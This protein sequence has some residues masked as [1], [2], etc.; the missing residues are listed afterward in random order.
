[1][2]EPDTPVA[3]LWG[4]WY[5]AFLRIPFAI[6]EELAKLAAKHEVKAVTEAIEITSRKLNGV[7]DDMRRISYIH[8]ILG[9][10]ILERIAPEKA[11]RMKE[12]YSLRVYWSHQPHG[13]GY[14]DQTAVLQWLECCTVDEI[15]AIMNVANGLWA[16]L[17][18]E[19][20]RIVTARTK[21]SSE[22]DS[23]AE[24]GQRSPT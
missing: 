8:G 2:P 12:F 22:R 4:D 7:S 14:L 3:S 17:K 1:L 23:L 10:K 19:M 15:R 18:S 6:S 9:H 16:E 20:E 5:L 24:V 11:A 21:Q 13:T